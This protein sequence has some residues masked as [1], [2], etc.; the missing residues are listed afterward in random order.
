VS[1]R[2]AL[3]SRFSNR[4]LFR[5]SFFDLRMRRLYQKTATPDAI[6]KNG[7]AHAQAAKTRQL[8]TV[9]SA[10]QREMIKHALESLV[11]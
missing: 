3:T 7:V 8:L 4:S 11:Y 6:S 1:Q 10:K 2:Q 5:K 9:S